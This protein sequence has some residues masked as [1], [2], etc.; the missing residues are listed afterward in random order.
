MWL[1]L[2]RKGKGP[3]EHC[4]RRSSDTSA[5]GWPSGYCSF[6]YPYSDGVDK[7]ECVDLCVDLFISYDLT[8]FFELQASMTPG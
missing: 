4:Q 1:R 8:H 2:E 7:P 3:V 6:D 5:E